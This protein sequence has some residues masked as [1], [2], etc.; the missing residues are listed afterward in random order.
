MTQLKHPPKAGVFT[1]RNYLVS[2][3]AAAASGVFISS[4][5]AS[6]FL[7]SSMVMMSFPGY[8]APTVMTRDCL[9]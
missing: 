1:T 2:S 3:V 9:E 7:I 8:G 6:W 5:L 4:G